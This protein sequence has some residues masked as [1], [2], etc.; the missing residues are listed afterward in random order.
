MFSLPKL[1]VGSLSLDKICGNSFTNI[2]FG[3]VLAFLVMV[4]LQSLDSEISPSCPM[5]KS[6]N[7]LCLQQMDIINENCLFGLLNNPVVIFVFILLL[8]CVLTYLVFTIF[9]KVLNKSNFCEGLTNCVKYP[10][11]SGGNVGGSGFGGSGVGGSG[12]RQVFMS[13]SVMDCLGGCP[14]GFGNK[15]PTNVKKECNFIDE[16]MLMKDNMCNINPKTKDSVD[17]D[18]KV[19]T[20]VDLNDKN[21]TGSKLVKNILEQFVPGLLPGLIGTIASKCDDN[22]CDDNKCDDKKCDDK[23]C[24][25]KK[26]DDKKCDDKKCDDKKNKDMLGDNIKNIKHIIDKMKGLIG[27]EKINM[28]EF[29]LD[30]LNL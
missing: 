16:C 20:N 8:N 14:L 25:D 23:K 5:F 21:D 7:N 22:K 10:L 6:Q 4:L 11:M 26:C 30:F 13:D 15:K 2:I 27:D 24:D 17:F 12:G 18:V 19:A 28:K 1:N 29:N 3:I 9:Q